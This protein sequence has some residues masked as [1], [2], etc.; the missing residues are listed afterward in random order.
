MTAPGPHPITTRQGKLVGIWAPVTVNVDDS[1]ICS[2]DTGIQYFS[3]GTYET[4]YQLGNWR[5]D[6]DKLTETATEATDA[7]E[8]DSIKIGHPIATRVRWQGPDTIVI[9]G[10]DGQQMKLRRCPQMSAPVRPVP[11]SL[12]GYGR[13]EGKLSY[14]SDYIPKDIVVCAEDMQAKHN[15]CDSKRQREGNGEFYTLIVPPGKY[16]V[17]AKTNDPPNV[18]AYYSEFVTCGLDAK[19]PSHKPLVVD[20]SPGATVTSVH[21]QDWY[22]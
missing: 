10:A 7:A 12:S 14:P 1:S 21:P 15:H 17:Y 4:L 13:I 16:H 18:R 3:D 9:T 6:G 20:V 11:E 5:L 8:P 22:N 2:G 19:C